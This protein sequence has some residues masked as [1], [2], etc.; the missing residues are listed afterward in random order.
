MRISRLAT[1]NYR[2]LENLDLLFPSFYSAIC[3]KNDSGKTN[4][5]RAIRCLMKEDEPFHYVGEPEFSLK[6]DYTNW[7]DTTESKARS[8]HVEIDL[9]I[10]A[11]SDTGLFEFFRD[12]LSLGCV[13]G[14]LDLKVAVT[15]ASA[16]AH[17]EVLAEDQRFDGLKAQ[18]VLKRLQTSRTFLF[19]SS[20][21]PH[22][23]FRRGFRGVPADITEEYTGKLEQSKKSVHR[24]L[25]RIA[26]EQQQEI[27]PAPSSV[28]WRISTKLA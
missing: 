9:R 16:G 11:E 3:G 24:V 28:D 4:V 15:H 20:T 21:D 2:T 7:L 10:N 1:K 19:H 23:R 27:E 17:V 6:N 26:R 13:S 12:Y 18:E 22:P 8:I 14:D 5:V 25:R